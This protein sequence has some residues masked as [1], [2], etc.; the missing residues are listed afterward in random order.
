MVG[1]NP[2]PSSNSVISH[3]VILN[4]LP[5]SQNLHTLGCKCGE[6]FLFRRAD[7]SKP[8]ILPFLSCMVARIFSWLR[9]NLAFII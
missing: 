4:Q 9:S 3:C 6:N 1:L 2:P 5:V 8:I 7:Y